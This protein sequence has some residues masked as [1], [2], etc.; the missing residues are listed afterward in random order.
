MVET[1]NGSGA[2]GGKVKLLIIWTNEM[3]GWALII[4]GPKCEKDTK[5][6]LII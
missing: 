2:R 1:K 4:H 3:H 5:L 6:L